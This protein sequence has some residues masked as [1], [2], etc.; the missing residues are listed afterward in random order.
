MNEQI[1]GI[2]LRSNFKRPSYLLQDFK[3]VR[4]KLLHSTI[5]NKEAIVVIIEDC[6]H[7]VSTIDILKKY[8]KLVMMSR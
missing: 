4:L 5:D 2:S 8:D 3:A 7:E 1:Y 6:D